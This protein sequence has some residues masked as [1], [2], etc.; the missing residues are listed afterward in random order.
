VFSYLGYKR[1]ASGLKKSAPSF[2][3]KNG[4]DQ[5]ETLSSVLLSKAPQ[6][7]RLVIYNRPTAS[8]VRRELQ[9]EEL[10]REGTTRPVLMILLGND[11]S[12]DHAVCAIDDL[13]FDS[14]QRFA[15]K[16]CLA[17]LNWVC[18]TCGFDRVWAAYELHSDH[19]TEEH[20]RR[21]AVSSM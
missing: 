13:L 4:R 12:N 7:A 9:L 17:S 10:L 21:K 19:G 6:F 5:V 18:G 1:Y 3:N 16:L 11:G 15:M 8:G 20:R 2:Q 14:T